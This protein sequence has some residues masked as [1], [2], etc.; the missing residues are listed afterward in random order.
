M[1]LVMTK[2]ECSRLVVRRQDKVDRRR[3]TR[4]IN[5]RR[6]EL[7]ITAKANSRRAR[8]RQLDAFTPNDAAEFMRL[9]RHFVETLEGSVTEQRYCRISRQLITAQGNRVKDFT[10]R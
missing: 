7:L 5:Q 8:R 10:L 4:S 2:L 1:T 9:L 3:K 6:P